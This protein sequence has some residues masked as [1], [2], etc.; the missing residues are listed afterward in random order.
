MFVLKDQNEE[1]EATEIDI[2]AWI[3]SKLVVTF[4]E[5]KAFL[6]K[7]NKITFGLISGE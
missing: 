3:L 2:Q 5:D 4:S 7:V 6:K 1:I